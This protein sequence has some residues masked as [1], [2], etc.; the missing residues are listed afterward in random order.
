MCQL[1]GV[2]SVEAVSAE[3]E[4]CFYRNCFLLLLELFAASARA[5]SAKQLLSKLFAAFARAAV[6]IFG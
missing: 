4:K 6:G 5:V 2:V 3:V 1:V